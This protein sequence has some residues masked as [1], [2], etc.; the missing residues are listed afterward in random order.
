MEANELHNKPGE[1]LK[2]NEG[3]DNDLLI[4]Y[5]TL[6]K[7]IGW[8]G[9]LLPVMLIVVAV[10]L[11]FNECLQPTISD[12]Y[13]TR[14]GD[15]LEGVL[16]VLAFF[17]FAYKGHGPYDNIITNFAGAFALG[18]SFFPTTVIPGAA[19]CMHHEAYP[20]RAIGIFHDVC[21]I[22]LFFCFAMISLR[23][24]TKINID[25]RPENFRVKKN[26][27]TT[28][29]VCGWLILIFIALILAYEF[30]RFTKHV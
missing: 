14:S 2:G 23:I 26:R 19:E 22:L 21:A 3:G 4:S 12:Y 24:F 28:F 18:V 30:L 1:S 20:C 13:Y 6:R 15:I 11:C 9:I 25:S 29:I 10:I 16:W 5:M 7:I 27:K 17:L 8:L